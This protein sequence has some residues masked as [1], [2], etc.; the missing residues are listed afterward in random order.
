MTDLR[1]DSHR[2]ELVTI[3]PWFVSIMKHPLSVVNGTLQRRTA[4]SLN[5]SVATG[6][7]IFVFHSGQNPRDFQHP[8]V[9]PAE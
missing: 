3:S 6:T 4:P 5:P 9:S 2:I 7:R 8:N 1:L